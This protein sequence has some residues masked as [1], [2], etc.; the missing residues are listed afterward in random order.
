MRPTRLRPPERILVAARAA[1]EATPRLEEGLHVGLPEQNRGLCVPRLDGALGDPC[2]EELQH[3]CEPLDVRLL[4]DDEIELPARDELEVVREQVEAACVD[5][6][7]A[8]PQDVPERE[9]AQGV[10]RDRATRGGP[11]AES[12]LDVL[13]LL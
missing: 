10:E 6:P 8:T 13:L 7:A 1:L 9:R 4:V 11:A 12:G 3:R 5:L 2:E